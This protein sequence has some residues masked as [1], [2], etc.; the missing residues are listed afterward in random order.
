[1]VGLIPGAGVVHLMRIT[2]KMMR[3]M[4]VLAVLFTV[5]GLACVV[6]YAASLRAEIPSGGAVVLE[7]LEVYVDPAGTVPIVAIDWDYPRPGDNM[8]STVY[9]ENTGNWPAR[10]SL[11][12][13][14][15]VPAGAE[16]FL[17]LSW[18]Y[19]GTPIE[20]GA[21]VTI[22][23]ELRVSPD[24]TGIREFTFDVVIEIEAVLSRP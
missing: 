23:L 21:L 7:G 19:T 5:L 1:M 15:W 11:S 9:V 20:P 17:A 6:V 3:F 10:V 8:T 13:S 12:A 22:V 2:R 24:V 18:D 16:A 14:G 4:P